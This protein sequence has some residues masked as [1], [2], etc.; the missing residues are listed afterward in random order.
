[1]STNSRG[2]RESEATPKTRPGDI[3][4]LVLGDPSVFGYGG[5]IE[6]RLTEVIERDPVL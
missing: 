4:L 3:K 5:R 2:F 1:M 6:S